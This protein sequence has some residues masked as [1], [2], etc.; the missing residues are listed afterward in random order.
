MVHH[1]P[2]RRVYKKDTCLRIDLCMGTKRT[3]IDTNETSH[4]PYKG[5]LRSSECYDYRRHVLFSWYTPELWYRRPGGRTT[6]CAPP[7]PSHRENTPKSPAARCCDWAAARVAPPGAAASRGRARAAAAG[8]E[9]SCET[10]VRA[11]RCARRWSPAGWQAHRYHHPLVV[12]MYAPRSPHSTP[13]SASS[14]TISRRRMG[15]LRRARRWS[16]PAHPPK[17]QARAIPRPVPPSPDR[18]AAQGLSSEH[19]APAPAPPRY[20]AR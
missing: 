7:A 14:R 10:K 2:T 18:S 17:G 11:D 15:Y 6:C 5:E 12:E 1:C 16:G 9:A 3:L 13:R 20:S 4:P 8:Y 19:H